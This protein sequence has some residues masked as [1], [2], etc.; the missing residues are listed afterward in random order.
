MNTGGSVFITGCSEGGIGHALAEVFHSRGFKVFASA[1]NVSKIG[2]LAEKSNVIPVELDVS[3]TRQIAAAVELV[4]KET[5]GTLTYLINN[6]GRNQYMPLLDQDIE[7][8]KDIFDTNVW[9]PLAITKAFSP[10]LI[11]AKGKVV[12]ISSVAGYINN[13]WMGKFVGDLNLWY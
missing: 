10:L 1:R 6:A 11:K 3:N 5:G 2:K 7:E 12:N 13:P 8:A 9:A 4:S